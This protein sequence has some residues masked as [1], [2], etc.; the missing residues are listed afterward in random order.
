MGFYVTSPPSSNDLGVIATGTLGSANAT[1]SA[2][3]PSGYRYLKAILSGV[4]TG[5]AGVNSIVKMRI[6]GV[7]SNYL[8]RSWYSQTTTYGADTGASTDGI[9]V[10]SVQIGEAMQVIICA[11]IV[12]PSGHGKNVYADGSA[13]EEATESTT[14]RVFSMGQSDD[15][16]EV[17]SISFVLGGSTWTTASKI[18]VMGFR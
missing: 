14:L 10:L 17:T 8:S 16:A 12:A 3:I 15:T 4:V 18:S 5:D 1:I 13:T 2:T 6:N 11:D 7:T 9:A